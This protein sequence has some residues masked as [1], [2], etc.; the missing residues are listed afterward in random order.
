MRP[1]SAAVVTTTGNGAYTMI[2]AMWQPA[3]QKGA[4]MNKFGLEI[5]NY[6]NVGDAHKH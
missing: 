2:K 4:E 6:K 5:L 3:M 1:F